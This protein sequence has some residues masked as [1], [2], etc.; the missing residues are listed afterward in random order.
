MFFLLSFIE[1][2]LIYDVAIISAVPQS[3]SIHWR[4]FLS[5]MGFGVSLWG[6]LGEGQWL[7][8]HPMASTLICAQALAAVPTV[9]FA[10]SVQ[11]SIQWK[12][13]ECLDMILRIVWLHRNL[14]S[15][16]RPWEIHGSC[17]E[18]H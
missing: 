16:W 6:V 5:D 12:D 10:S 7:S 11:I 13:K 3:D 2:Y 9:A 18:N 15:S 8:A 17:F 1:V 4:M 14:E